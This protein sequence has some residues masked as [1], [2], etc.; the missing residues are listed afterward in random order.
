M[1][2]QSFLA[3]RPVADFLSR[4]A[5]APRQAHKS[6]TLWPLLS[7]LAVSSVRGPAYIPLTDAL[8]AGALVVDEVSEHGSVPHVRVTNRGKCAVLVLF[9]E[10]LRGAKQNRVANAS[11]LIGAKS[12]AVIDVSCVE[13][14][15]WSR[16]EGARF[17]AGLGVVS[18]RMRSRMQADVSEARAAGHGFRA[19]QSAVWR[20]VDELVSYSRVS[21]PTNAYAD[22]YASRSGDVEEV[23]KAFRAVPHQVGFI[24]ATGDA[25]VGLEAIGR[26]EVFERVFDR[27]LRAY[28]IDAVDAGVSLRAERPH[29]RFDSPESFVAALC[30]ASA[31]SSPSLGLG[32]D[33]RLAGE[34]VSGCG[35][36]ADDLVHLT[37][38]AE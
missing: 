13:Q 2:P 1:V 18:S 9:G 23:C 33:L 26:P 37:A 28:A 4:I 24:A 5:L 7:P 17:E 36:A 12:E 21:S 31:M 22:Y 34:G 35:L 3:S 30:S 10:E 20:E 19:D 25:V 32:V 6:M 16:R 38:F 11:F 8:A 15:R 14:G 29:A 27:L